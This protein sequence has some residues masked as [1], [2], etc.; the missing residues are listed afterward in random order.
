MSPERWEQVRDLF[1]RL[2]TLPPDEQETA[3]L[4]LEADEDELRHEVAT[5]LA[6]A[7]TASTIVA[8]THSA[9]LIAASSGPTPSTFGR[10]VVGRRLGAGGMGVVYEAFDPLRAT[11]VALKA[12]I[13]ITPL[14]V[15]LF[16]NEFR[17]LA[18]VHHQNL[19]TLYDLFEHDRRWFFTMEFVEGQTLKRHLRDSTDRWVA[20]R[21]VLAAIAQGL[22][23]LHQLRKLHRDVKPSNVMVSRDGR[24]LILD[25]G[26]VADLKPTAASDGRFAGTREYASPEQSRGESLTTA[27]DCYSLGVLL[28]E[29]LT[30]HLPPFRRGRDSSLMLESGRF[31]SIPND[32][33]RLCK[34]LLQLV[35]ERRPSASDVFERTGTGAA[36][37]QASA[38]WRSEELSINP[39]VGRADELRKLDRALDDTASGPVV[40]AVEGRSGVGKTALVNQFLAGARRRSSTMVVHGRCYERESISFNVFDS[41][42]DELNIHLRG[43]D[44]K[45]L[46]GLLPSD[47]GVLG[48]MFP[49]LEW[50]G[51]LAP[52]NLRYTDRKQLRRVGCRVLRELLLNLGRAATLVV[53]VDDLQWSDLD[54][55]ELIIE[56]LRD[57]NPPALL[58]ILGFR[59]EDRS[60]SKTVPLLLAELRKAP[61]VQLQQ[62]TLRALRPES[63]VAVANLLL[64]PTREHAG[65]VTYAEDIARESAGNPYSSVDTSKPAI[66]RH[67][68]TGH[69]ARGERGGL[70]STAGP[71][72][73]ASRRAVWCASCVGRT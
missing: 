5:L 34:D 59:S 25:F 8:D 68:K 56:L 2:V 46:A 10:F 9:E 61:H 18:D 40:I 30:G 51:S 66:D 23:A 7:Q 26:L 6:D 60:R 17:S 63:A 41:L 43:M 53:F 35:P 48:H 57:S 47:V 3:L 15:E 22:T 45:R 27:S 67:F 65:A 32:L 36:T 37:R 62:L 29:A 20:V 58:L 33:A 19:V 16:R 11:R 14:S 64:A 70:S 24:V 38:R 55:A 52:A 13:R 69:H 12:L 21:S 71:P 54:S 1:D 42:S 28:F 50:L 31:G 72:W 44:A 4:A 39:F 49:R 73:T